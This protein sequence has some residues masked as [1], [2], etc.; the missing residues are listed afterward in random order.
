MSQI[1]GPIEKRDILY[2]VKKLSTTESAKLVETLFHE[3]WLSDSADFMAYSK[4]LSGLE[5]IRSRAVEEGN[6]FLFL[7][8]SRLLEEAEV[9]K[10]SLL[11]CAINA[12]KSGKIRYA[13]KAYEKL[14]NV[15]KVEE[16]RATIATDGDIIA[17]AEQ[18]VFI[19]ETEEE[20]LESAEEE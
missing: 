5:K 7:K 10:D 1:P 14:G 17:E 9:P 19:P 13:M 16:L 18:S 4:D 6:S 11:A 15:D 20:F 2:G 12:E 8:V 3:G